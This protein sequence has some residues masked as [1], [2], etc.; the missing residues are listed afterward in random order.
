VWTPADWY[1]NQVAPSGYRLPKPAGIATAAGFAW[2]TAGM[3]W[4]VRRRDEL[5]PDDAGAET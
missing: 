3:W 2:L 5:I 4:W 1:K